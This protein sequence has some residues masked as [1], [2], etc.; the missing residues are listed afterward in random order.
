[1]NEL[2]YEEQEACRGSPKF[3]ITMMNSTDSKYKLGNVD[4]TKGMYASFYLPETSKGQL[5]SA[6]KYSTENVDFFFLCLEG[7][8]I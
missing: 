8:T 4:Y 6:E 5:R 1:M 2:C 7:I 3:V